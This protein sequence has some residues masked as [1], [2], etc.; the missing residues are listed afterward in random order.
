MP[1]FPEPKE[2]VV[3]LHIYDVIVGAEGACAYLG[4]TRDQETLGIKDDSL[5]KDSRKGII[6]G[7]LG[8]TPLIL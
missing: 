7:D 2:V 3:K 8:E 6:I 4:L 1:G 5:I